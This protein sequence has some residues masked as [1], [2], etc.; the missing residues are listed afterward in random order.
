MISKEQIQKLSRKKQID[1]DTILREY[2][3]LVFLKELYKEKGSQK[4]Y[5][6][7]G[8]AIHLLF[9]APR[10]SMDLD[11]TTELSSSC[12]RGLLEK[13]VKR[14][15]LE[16]PDVK[17]KPSKKKIN[18]SFSKILSYHP[19]ERRYPL[20]IALD[21]SLRE[22]PVKEV[23]KAVLKTEFPI[24]G[25]SVILHLD[26]QE[27]LAEKVRTV[28][29][30]GKGRDLYDL[31][32]LMSKNIPINW[33]LVEKKMQLYPKAKRGANFKILIEKIK[34]FK[35]SSLVQDLAQFLPEVER[36]NFLP[37]LKE[38]LIKELY[39]IQGF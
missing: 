13:I 23:Q 36:K 37:K 27:I 8:T 20:N 12:I 29:I 9:G 3:Q 22:K 4:I 39:R 35:E 32:Y 17:L 26:W 34:Q 5:F 6:K 25:A 30:R 19:K 28:L 15:N 24:S 33:E 18:H 11:F 14:V 2:F 31:Y 10:F 21:F 1:Q 16:S 38:E 7:G